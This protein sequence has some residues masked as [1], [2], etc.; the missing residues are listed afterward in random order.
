MGRKS[1]EGKTSRTCT[2]GAK[3]KKIYYNFFEIAFNGYL[4]KFLTWISL[5]F[6][7]EA[8][9]ALCKIQFTIRTNFWNSLYVRKSILDI[10]GQMF[11]SGVSK[12]CEERI[13][14]SITALQHWGCCIVSLPFRDMIIE[15]S[16][17]LQFLATIIW[18]NLFT[19][20]Q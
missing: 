16:V 13:M 14:L 7:K 4:D 2:V 3:I 1:M 10:V 17:I 6:P 20:Y 5:H 18:H 8:L 19:A 9:N 11:H 15:Q 12:S